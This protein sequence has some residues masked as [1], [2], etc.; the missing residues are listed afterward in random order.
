MCFAILFYT[1]G[2]IFYRWYINKKQ[3]ENISYFLEFISKEMT[4]LEKNDYIELKHI[5]IL[6]K[7]LKK[8]NKLIAFEKALEQ[9]KNDE[10]FP[11]Y[12]N[13]LERVIKSIT[14]HYKS[15][16]QMEQAYLARFI[17]EYAAVGKW[18]HPTIYK[19]LVS[20]LENAT[21]YLRESVL[22]ATYQQPDSKW[23]INVFNYLSENNLFHHPKLIQDGLM[24]YPYD[25]DILIDDLWEKHDTFEESILLGL[26]GY[27]TFK[28]DWFKETFYKMLKDERLNLEV[29][30]RLIRYFKR[31]HYPKVEPLLIDFLKDEQDEIRIVTAHTLGDYHSEH[32][33]NSL[34]EALKDFNFYVRRNAIQSLLDLGA[35][36][37]DLYDILNGQDRYAKEMLLYQLNKKAV[38]VYEP[39]R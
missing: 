2:F 5:G 22:L 26:L 37:Q 11:T 15:R 20:Y 7:Q 21:I 36:E 3:S 34:K 8:I 18:H 1:L 17:A 4:L 14:I 35:S 19:T 38:K 13:Q 27:I 25:S 33:I 6:K 16:N 24:K 30:I 23:I 9:V 32:V 12:L 29:K 39:I 28:S 31:H 10:Q